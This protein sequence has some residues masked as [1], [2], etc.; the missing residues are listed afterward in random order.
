MM[1]ETAEKWLATADPAIPSIEW[2]RTGWCRFPFWPANK[3]FPSTINP[4]WIS[5]SAR[6]IWIYWIHAYNKSGVC[7]EHGPNTIW[8]YGCTTGFEKDPISA[9]RYRPRI[10]GSWIWPLAPRPAKW[11]VFDAEHVQKYSIFDLQQMGCISMSICDWNG[12]GNTLCLS[13]LCT[14]LSFLQQ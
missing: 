1:A 12:P 6:G 13:T 3:S 11:H 9:M 5:L 8:G 14:E 10:Q 7:T 4:A 2:P